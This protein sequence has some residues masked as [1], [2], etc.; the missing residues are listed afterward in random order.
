MPWYTP[1]TLKLMSEVSR[2]N[3]MKPIWTVQLILRESPEGLG[4]K[5]DR[6]AYKGIDST[7][8]RNPLALCRACLGRRLY[9]S[10]SGLRLVPAALVTYIIQGTLLDAFA[11]LKEGNIG[12]SHF[13]APVNEYT[14]RFYDIK[15]QQNAFHPVWKTDNKTSEGA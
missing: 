9:F 8:T 10:A 12:L 13:T 2:R 6:G 14:Y 15:N 7:L 1:E 4:K 3:K 11:A 5:Q